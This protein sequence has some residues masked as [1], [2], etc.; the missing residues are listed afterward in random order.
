[1]R[2]F[3][4][5]N[6][7]FPILL[8][9]AVFLIFILNYV[10]GTW[11]SGWD[12][13]HPEF[14]FKLNFNRVFN[15][16]WRSE[17]GLGAPAGHSHMSELPRILLLW[18]L[19][20]VFPVSF[21]RW[22]FIF[23][24]LLLGV[25]GIY[26]FLK[27]AIFKDKCLIANACC[28]LG[29]LFY[30]L[31]LGTLQ[32]FYVPFE[33]FCVLYA[34]LPWILL[35]VFNYLTNGRKRSLIWFSVIT[36]L[37]APMAYAAT[38]WYVYFVFFTLFLISYWIYE[39]RNKLIFKRSLILIILTLLLN[40]FWLL[41]NLFYLLSGAGGEVTLS[42]T[43]L[44]FSEKAFG[45]DA[46]YATFTNAAILKGFLFDWQKF[47]GNNFQNLMEGWINYLSSPIVLVIGYI[48]FLIVVFGIIA[49]LFKRK[50][51]L[52]IVLLPGFIL[53]FIFLTYNN[54]VFRNIFLLLRDNIQT[55]KEGLR[56]PW[57]K[58]SL[59]VI[60]CF[61]IYFSFG[62]FLIISK[63]KR[64][65]AIIF[66]ILLL[67][68]IL[69]MWPVFKGEFINKYIKVKIP[70][71]YFQTYE[72][73]NKQ[74]KNQRIGFF[75]NPSVFGW[76]YYHWGFEGAGFIWFGLPQP[77]LVRDF[78]RWNKT[79]EN[80]Y[81]EVTNAVYSGNAK[82]FESIFEKY[83]ISWAIVDGN[84]IN[85]AWPAS[86]F[87][88][89]SEKLFLQS[90]KFEKKEQFGN[91]RIYSFDLKNRPDNFIFIQENLFN[92]QPEYKWNNFDQAYLD[93]GNYTTRQNVNLR[94]ELRSRE[95]E[96]QK[97]I[98]YP[99]RSLF[100]GRRQE[101]L[102]FI[103]KEDLDFFYFENDLPKDFIKGQL[104]VPPYFIEEIE[105]INWGSSTKFVQKPP[106][107]EIINNKVIVKIPKIWGYNSY[108]L[109]TSGDFFQNKAENCGFLSKPNI[110]TEITNDF[111]IK[112][113]TIDSKGC[114]SY[115]AT[116]LS[117]RIGYLITAQTNNVSGKPFLFW[118][119]N[120]TI[121][122]ADLE[123]YLP[124]GENTS[125]IIQ[126]PMENFGVG[127]GLH[128]DNISIGKEK[129]INELQNITVN[130]IPWRF[131]TELKIVKNTADGL[132]TTDYSN[133][134][135]VEHQNQSFYKVKISSSPSAISNKQY[136]VLS[137]S[138]DSG[139]IAWKGKMF[140]GKKLPHLLINNWENGWDLS[141][142]LSDQ[143]T[144]T[145][146]QLPI[147]IYIF[148]WPQLL[149]YFGYLLLLG[150]IVIIWRWRE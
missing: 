78:D 34:G 30:L 89:N 145:Q 64:F 77:V 140:F 83:Q 68:L 122:R 61:S 114:L 85:P 70:Q 69:W 104:I 18:I 50:N 52:M 150:G 14:D 131:L 128:F 42:Q 36:L 112:I 142:V 91:I 136:L 46:K 53:S 135:K 107:V 141:A 59:F 10:P 126:P 17:Q 4:K 129:T 72:Y 65:K 43:N 108:D 98:Y 20:F 40:L 22:L 49:S 45:H 138:F 137:Q 109:Y 57:T 111:G 119:E 139:W 19:S 102:E 41:P 113:S 5:Y 106:V 73:F 87:S 44:L 39:K 76:E 144:N 82:Q 120:L 96:T 48:L 74:D 71:E 12:T 58:F 93:Y 143:S 124:E 147:T 123:T 33:M 29:S 149:Q 63:V 26:F 8:V 88:E 24:C 86:V 13:L 67:F 37:S 28:F 110:K 6:Y 117:N 84:M 2:K 55:L 51:N 25:L 1:M 132:Q 146:P 56:F 121:K 97:V 7:L 80:Y 100:T 9:F 125:F 118:I 133:E 62:S 3:F 16:V 60:F 15:G 66:S 130:P 35:T 75:P 95:S 23:L 54:F 21:L 90:K 94:P 105:E 79:N 47:N 27:K 148:Y 115:I 103:V 101:D 32:H 38:L 92:I 99:F 127:Y 134:L 11:L 31:N 116:N 81:W